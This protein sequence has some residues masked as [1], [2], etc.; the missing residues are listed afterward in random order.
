M[1]WCVIS[2]KSSKSNLLL[3]RLQ[4]KT[5]W[6]QRNHS[7]LQVIDISISTFVHACP[8]LFV[9]LTLSDPTLF[10]WFLLCLEIQSL[11]S[12]CNSKMHRKHSKWK[13]WIRLTNWS[14]FSYKFFLKMWKNLKLK[15]LLKV[16]AN[17]SKNWE[18]SILCQEWQMRR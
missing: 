4:F 15:N 18:S 11:F 5:N 10:R 3:P 6:C 12:W 1:A 2:W 14:S 8:Y 7:T 9:N 16:K 17:K 13:I